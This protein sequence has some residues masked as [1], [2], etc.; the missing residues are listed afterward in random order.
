MGYDLH[1]TRAQHHADSPE[2][3]ITLKEWQA[4]LETDPEMRP[5]GYAEVRVDAQVLRYENPGLAVWTGWSRHGQGSDCAWFNY[6]RGEIVVKNP[7]EEMLEKMKRIARQ[8]GARVMGD[9]GEEY[10]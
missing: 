2:F 8:L 3:P 10:S 1:I 6:D 5:D 7:D 9:E 4:Y